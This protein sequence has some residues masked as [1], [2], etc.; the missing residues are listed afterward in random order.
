MLI[1]TVII[2]ATVNSPEITSQTAAFTS[3]ESISENTPQSIIE[4]IPENISE[5]EPAHETGEEWAYFIVNSKYPLPA[6]YDKQ[7]ILEKIYKDFSLDSRCAG[8]ARELIAAAEKDGITLVVISAYRSFQKQRENFDDYIDRLIYE[9]YDREEAAKI[10]ASQI[11]LPGESEHNA[12][13]SID[14]IN[15]D[16]YKTHDD[17]TDDFENTAEFE[18]LYENSWKFGFILRYHKDKSDIT[19]FDYEPWHYR[20]VGEAKAKLIYDSGLTLDEYYELNER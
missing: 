20:Y 19:G 13:V 2:L 12:G 11:A 4:S 5:T 3:S 17:I 10:T 18:W 8:K 1:C 16:W 9:G 7:I 14:V 15:K 6:D